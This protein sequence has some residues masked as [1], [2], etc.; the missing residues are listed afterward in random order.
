MSNDLF[1]ISQQSGIYHTFSLWSRLSPRLSKGER[2][3]PDP[4]SEESAGEVKSDDHND[5]GI[6]DEFSA[7]D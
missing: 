2:T 4:V 5:R 7:T 6:P 3:E 1:R